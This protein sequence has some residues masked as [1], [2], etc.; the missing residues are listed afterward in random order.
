MI[1]TS[2]ELHQKIYNPYHQ[3]L[4]CI[5]YIGYIIILYYMTLKSY[6]VIYIYMCVCVYV[7]VRIMESSC[8]AHVLGNSNSSQLSGSAVYSSYFLIT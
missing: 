3:K 2:Q 8:N 5:L 1:K 6:T 7:C 4:Y